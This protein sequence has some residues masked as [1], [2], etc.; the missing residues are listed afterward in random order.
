MAIIEKKRIKMILPVPMP[1]EAISL[2]ADQIPDHFR[3][4]DI[5][6]DFVAPKEG[7]YLVDSY[8]EMALADAFV[9]DAG[10]KAEEEGYSAVCINSMSDSGLNALRSLLT[11]PVVGPC[12][13][14]LLTACMLG[15]KFSILTMWDKWHPLYKKTITEQG[16]DHRLASIRSIDVRPD[17]EELLAGKE[18]MVFDLLVREGNAAIEQDGADVLILGST[19]MHQSHNY[20]VENMAVPVLNPGLVALKVCEN[21]LDM[22]LAQSKKSY[23]APEIVNKKLFDAIKPK[24]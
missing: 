10:M 17:T 6:I 8:Y 16:L 19:S 5:E 12:Q 9:L 24:F 22:G 7:A 23:P 15:Q 20:L 1:E 4:S 21:L 2:F 14:T 3:R 11:I 13:S 18:D